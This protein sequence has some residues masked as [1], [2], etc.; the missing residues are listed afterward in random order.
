MRHVVSKMTNPMSRVLRAL[1]RMNVCAARSSTGSTP[2]SASPP[3]W[4]AA[5]RAIF[6]GGWWTGQLEVRRVASQDRVAAF[7]LPTDGHTLL[8][9]QLTFRPLK[10]PGFKVFVEGRN[11]TNVEAREHAS[12]LKDI[13]P[14]PGRNLRIG[15]GYRF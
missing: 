1:S 5:G 6:D 3:P 10:D 4:S 8:N 7:E 13:A 12:F 9:A 2:S 15:A 14:M 11:L